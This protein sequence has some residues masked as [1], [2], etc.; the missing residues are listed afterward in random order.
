MRRTRN[1]VDST[2]EDG[3]PCEVALEFRRTIIRQ[4][5]ARDISAD[6]L[7]LAISF[8]WIGKAISRSGALAKWLLNKIDPNCEDFIRALASSDQMR[9]AALSDALTASATTGRDDELRTIREL[10]AFKQATQ[11]LRHVTSSSPKSVEVLRLAE[12]QELSSQL[13]GKQVKCIST[14]PSDN[15]LLFPTMRKSRKEKLRN[16]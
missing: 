10:Q 16:R 12:L 13:P 15:I 4:D 1:Q 9:R 14:A 6:A 2:S 5:I 7:D 8:A 11:A 3:H